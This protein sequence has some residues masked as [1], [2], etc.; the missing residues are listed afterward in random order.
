M[1]SKVRKYLDMIA[2]VLK[3][4]YNV[5]AIRYDGTTSAT[6]RA[7]IEDEFR[8]CYTSLPMLTTSGAATGKYIVL[9]LFPY[10]DN[11]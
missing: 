7:D 8:T 4:E 1:F 2:Y 6:S 3:Q 5:D 9:G 10:T 11:V